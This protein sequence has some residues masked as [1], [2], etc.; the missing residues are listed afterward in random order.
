MSFIYCNENRKEE[1][2]NKGLVLLKETVFNGNK[3]FVFVNDKKMSFENM[4]G[5]FFMDKL[6]F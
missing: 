1:L 2:I 3:S 6:T 4:D 5:L